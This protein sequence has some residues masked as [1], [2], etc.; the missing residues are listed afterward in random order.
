MNSGIVPSTWWTHEFAGHNDEA[1]KETISLLGNKAFSTPKPVRLLLRLLRLSTCYNEN[2]II[3]DFFSGSAITAH[4][5][6]QLNA[7]DGGNRR[8]ICVQLP[9][10]CDEKNEAYKAGYKTI[11]EIGK[12]RIR[13]AGAK[14]LDEAAEANRQL[15]LG[16]EE[17]ALPDVVFKVYKLDISNLAEWDASPHPRP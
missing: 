14:I 15:K 8:F 13:R 1:A 7:E 4:A 10:L 9:E 5:V 2:D 12:E 6:M 17:K 11:C 3:L 16:E